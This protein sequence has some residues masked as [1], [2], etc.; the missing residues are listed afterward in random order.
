MSNEESY[1]NVIID[2][3]WVARTILSLERR[4]AAIHER[5][6]RHAIIVDFISGLDEFELVTILD[7][8]HQRAKNGFGS[9]REVLQEFSLEPCAISSLPYKRVQKSYA[10]AMAKQLPDVAGMFLGA[11]LPQSSI[12]IDEAF[13]GNDYL[14]IPLGIRR[15]AARTKDRFLIDRLLHDRDHRVIKL[16]LE[17]PRVVER[18]V[19]SIAAR[20]PTRPEILEMISKHRKWA[21]RYMVRKALCGNPY[22]PHQIAFR[23]LSTLMLQDLR[24]YIN[25]GVFTA[26]LSVEARRILHSKL[27]ESSVKKQEIPHEEYNENKKSEVS[28]AAE[29]LLSFFDGLSAEAQEVY[30]NQDIHVEDAELADLIGQAELELANSVLKPVED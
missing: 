21:S 19:V 14:D 20:R 29:E 12:T 28:E 15:Q 26:D 25:S 4:I 17:N 10:I 9:S 27:G 24:Y 13:T 6:M 16:L 7:E 5:D 22:T 11:P 1:E 30:P 2:L 23:L 8:I 18:D 3:Q